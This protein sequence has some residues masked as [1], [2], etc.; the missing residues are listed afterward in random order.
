MWAKET[1]RNQRDR[2][3][4][5]LGGVERFSGRILVRLS[6]VHFESGEEGV[7]ES[8]VES[9]DGMDDGLCLVRFERRGDGEIGGGV[10]E[11][12]A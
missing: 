1:G 7:L 6:V 11:R 10:L 2:V 5:L 12:S 3:T 4:Y 9:D 8:D